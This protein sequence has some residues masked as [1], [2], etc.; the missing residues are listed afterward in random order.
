MIAVDHQGLADDGFAGKELAV[1]FGA[2]ED[3]AGA[4]G[5][6]LL[7]HEASLLDGEGAKALI[8]RPDSAYGAAG[9]VPLADLGDGAA[10]LRA[11]GF[12]ERGL[13]LDGDGVVDG[14]A[15]VAAGGVSAGLCA[16]L[17]AEED[18][19]VGADAAQMLLLINVEAD[20][21]TDQQND[22][23]DAPH[24]A[25]HGQEAAK[26]RLPEGGQRLLED[27]VERHRRN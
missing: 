7:A 17:A 10:Q 27:L 22:R 3:D 26:L 13:L 2:E 25:E 19:D 15:N 20:A 18:G 4:F 5:L 1:G 14:E 16:G 6:V 12:D 24:D 11:Y 9:C 23:G 21:E 8:L